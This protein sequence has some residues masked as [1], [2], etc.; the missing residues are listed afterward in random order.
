MVVQ[1]EKIYIPENFENFEVVKKAL[2]LLLDETA[3]KVLVKY[4][5][6]KGSRIGVVETA[7]M[8]QPKMRQTE[9][10]TMLA[11][12]RKLNLVIFEKEGKNVYYEVNE[13]VLV[14]I[15][16]AKARF[17]QKKLH[18]LNDQ[19]HKKMIEILSTVIEGAGI[20]TL[21]ILSGYKE[22]VTNKRIHYGEKG[23][24]RIVQ[25]QC[26]LSLGKLRLSGLV[27]SVK[28]PLN[29]QETLNKLEREKME[30]LFN[31][32]DEVYSLIKQEL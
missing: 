17:F 18:L 1:E 19:D 6:F 11:S 23:E 4:L 7:E 22:A 27:S 29:K 2:T 28:N 8:M 16:N 5:S 26:A 24:L 3:E 13:T 9:L 31:F 25:S 10:S 21:C 14:G 20:P 32:V 30:L 15:Q 12:L